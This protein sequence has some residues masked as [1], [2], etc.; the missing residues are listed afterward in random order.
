VESLVARVVARFGRLD[1]L[2]N[3]AGL[4]LLKPVV[5]T[6]EADMRRCLDVMVMGTFLCSREAGRHWLASGRGGRI[7]N[8]ASIHGLVGASLQSAY[9]AA[10]FGVVG[11]TKSMAME[12]ADRG[13][14]VNA[15]CPGITDT[16]M[17]GDLSAA[18]A[19]IRG[20]PIDEVYGRYRS[21]VPAG[22]LAQPTEIANAVAFLAGDGAEYVTGHCLRVDGGFL[23]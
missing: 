19:E 18:R 4:A 1:V 15:V 14:T 21:L 7:V 16:D 6:T 23:G 13:I 10:K 11:L 9:C 22:R 12:W 17:I 3:N 2:V 20:V 5:E 8:I